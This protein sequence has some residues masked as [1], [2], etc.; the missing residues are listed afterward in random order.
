MTPTERA[1]SP[2]R[3]S[4]LKSTLLVILMP[5]VIIIMLVFLW[6][7]NQSLQKQ[8][9]AAFDRSLAG[10]LRSIEVNIRTD[11]GG[12]GMEQPFYLLE[13]L[14]LTTRSTVFFRV[15]TEDNLSEIGYS[16]LPL[17]EATLQTNHPVFYNSLYAG[18]QIRLA[19]VAVVPE[20]G[21]TYS[22]GS[23]VIIQVGEN[24]ESRQDFINQVVLQSALK[25]AAVVTIIT[26]L[27]SV[28]VILVLRPLK[29]T[30]EDI[31]NRSFNDLQP[32]D[33]HDLPREIQPM[34]QAINLHMERYANKA[35]S[36]QQF[37]DDASHQLRTPLSVLTTQ[38][39]YARQIADTPEM[40]EVLKAIQ[41]RIGNTIRLTN[42]LVS[43]AKVNDAADK[44]TSR[45]AR[46]HVDLCEV[47]SQVVNDMLPAA[48]RKRMDFGL[49]LPE[50]TVT[51]SGIDWLVNQA[52][53]NMVSNAILYCP[54]RSRITVSAGYHANHP[55]IQV[56]DNGPGMSDQDIALAG[57]RFRRGASGKALHGSGLGLAIVQT[58]ADIHNATM[59]LRRSGN[60]GGLTA[61]LTFPRKI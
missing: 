31:R 40:D 37:L 4:S 15:A 5:A 16:D 33:E 52:L 17:P 23:R 22:P 2:I 13:F 42:Q 20:P 38:V 43:L 49:E 61:R 9:N 6:F 30:S 41:E 36:Q 47:A 57:R 14:A 48:R 55:Y 46:Q 53:T 32:I 1:P 28:G 35:R 8:V 51:A 27:L 50:L 26:L 7:S 18:E 19:A 56:E 58:I 24:I 10:A 3:M 60:D 59:E 44:L 21:I 29:K 54:A 25:D 45:A 11:S 39:E 34:V 12:L